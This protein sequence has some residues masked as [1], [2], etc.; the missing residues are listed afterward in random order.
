MINQRTKKPYMAYM[1]NLDGEI[2]R[3]E[4]YAYNIN[5]AQ[6]QA[7]E[8]ANNGG[9]RGTGWTVRNIRELEQ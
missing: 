2:E 6:Q 4:V 8:G 1:K 5:L 7:I 9:L 3:L